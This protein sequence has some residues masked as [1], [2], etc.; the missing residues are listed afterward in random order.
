LNVFVDW[1][2]MATSEG[3]VSD[4][5]VPAGAAP[6]LVMTRTVKFVGTAISPASATLT[7]YVAAG[8]DKAVN[9]AVSVGATTFVAM[10]GEHVDPDATPRFS[11]RASCTGS[12]LLSVRL[13][14]VTL[15]SLVMAVVN[16]NAV[17]VPDGEITSEKYFVALTK[18]VL[19]VGDVG[20]LEQPAINAVSN[21]AAHRRR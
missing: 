17:E 20:E 3:N 11:V 19:V 1:P 13:A 6:V 8:N 7:Q 9:D 14:S 18:P 12:P 2:P 21:S 16:V 4:V 10:V 5:A 15:M